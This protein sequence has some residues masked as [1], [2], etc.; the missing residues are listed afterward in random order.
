[1]NATERLTDV[2]VRLRYLS[3]YRLDVL[4]LI[5]LALLVRFHGISIPVVWYDEAYSLL[6]SERSPTLIWSITADDI[7]PPLYYVVLHYWTMMFGNSALSARSL[8]A[9]ADVGTL[10]LCIKLMSLIA[11]RRAA[12]IAGVLLVLLPI[13]VRYSQEARMYAMLGF[14]L[15]AATVALVCWSRQPKR[16]RY[17][18]IYALLMTAAFYTHYLAA[19]CVLVH[20][21]Y[22]SGLGC[23]ESAL[24]P[25]R[26]WL[27]ANAAIVVLYSPWLPHFIHQAWNRRGLEWITPT[28]WDMLP[29][30]FSQFTVMISA[31]DG[32]LGWALS[33]SVLMIVCG[34]MA[35]RQGGND[36]R[37]RTLLVCYF[38]LPVITV[39]FLSWAVPVFLYRYLVFAAVGLP[40]VVALVLDRLALKHGVFAFVCLCVCIAGETHGL[41]RV[42][43]QEDGLNG[44]FGRATRLDSLAE[45]V[46]RLAEAGDEIVVNYL[47]WYLPYSYYNTTGIQPRLYNATLPGGTGN[48]PAY[49]GELLV[50]LRAFIKDI[51]TVK[52]N[53]QR[54]WWVAPKSL[55][56]DI[57]TFPRQWRLAQVLTSGQMEARLFILDGER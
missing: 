51:S 29:G 37:S 8:S 24:L 23:G 14:W 6:L 42:Y 39:F 26:K 38:Y 43:A 34:V 21:L 30:L 35:L 9:L 40:M 11:T 4:A 7:H 22:W 41:L 57:H 17:P 1:M 53:S 15:M 31:S 18:V 50:P 52:L 55:A 25:L 16:K 28:T 56:E 5:T 27:M 19:L 13:S 46:N 49:G 33:I 20:W 32:G 10:L 44:T 47:Y 3:F 54:V 2:Q 48:G 12:C 36:R 45:G